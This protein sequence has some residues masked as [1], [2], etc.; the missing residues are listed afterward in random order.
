MGSGCLFNFNFAQFANFFTRSPLQFF[1]M[2]SPGPGILISLSLL[3]LSNASLE[4][5]DDGATQD[6]TKSIA[7]TH[8]LYSVDELLDRARNESPIRSKD[9]DGTT[10]GKAQHLAMTPQVSALRFP[11]PLVSQTHPGAVRSMRAMQPLRALGDEKPAF[12]DE[13]M[14]AINSGD[15]VPG[16]NT[17]EGTVGR[18]PPTMWPAVYDWVVQRGLKTVTSKRAQEMIKRE[19]AQVVDVR[20]ADATIATSF[21]RG[22]IEGAVN[23]PLFQKV[24]GNSAF[25]WS[26][27]AMMTFFGMEAT[28][29]NPDFEK[30][31]LEKLKSDGLFGLSKP[32]I[33][34]CAR[35]GEVTKLDKMMDYQKAA[36]N[37]QS[38]KAAYELYQAG[39]KNLYILEG[40]LTAW[41]REGLPMD[42]PDF[43]K[44]TFTLPVR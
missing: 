20:V 30:E 9:L 13:D 31:A 5:N 33:I 27:R 35:G 25:D 39:F 24:T 40:G 21:D 44:P 42:Y 38:L 1:S 12:K 14:Q 2:R 19:G 15:I 16:W 7:Q 37:T 34:V 8:A 11:A 23:V 43:V 3:V 17:R 36:Y 41:E 18:Y 28:E 29:Q 10:L 22:S 4:A 32:I 6:T 26:K